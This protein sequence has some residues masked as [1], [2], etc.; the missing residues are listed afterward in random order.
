M[1]E[2]APAVVPSLLSSEERS[3]LQELYGPCWNTEDDFDDDVPVFLEIMEIHRAAGV[4]HWFLPFHETLK[5]EQFETEVDAYRAAGR[6]SRE[7]N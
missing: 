1:P 7:V 4:P 3:E 2:P 6:V 5:H